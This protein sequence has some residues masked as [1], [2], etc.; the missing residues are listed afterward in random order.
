MNSENNEYTLKEAID[1]ML[2]AYRLK[3]KLN[4][5]RIVEQW[6]KLMGQMIARHTR[7]IYIHDHKLF[8][9]IDS[10]PLRNELH[11][12]KDKIVQ[13]LNDAMNDEV[14]TDVVIR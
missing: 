4:E 11:Y 3:P 8:L 9:T 1:K 10:A 6:E 14:I 7:Q 13:V 12:A 2:E 5:T